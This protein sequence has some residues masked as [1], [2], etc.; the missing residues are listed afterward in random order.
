MRPAGFTP[1]TTPP[2]APLTAAA[3]QP[4][5]P[6]TAPAVDNV[7]LEPRPL[8]TASTATPVFGAGFLSFVASLAVLFNAIVLL[9]GD[10][11]SLP[12]PLPP[13]WLPF[14]MSLVVGG[15]DDDDDVVTG[16]IVVGDVVAL[17]AARADGAV[18]QAASIDMFVFSAAFV[19]VPMLLL[20]SGVVTGESKDFV[21][22]W[23]GSG[24]IDAFVQF[25]Y[26]INQL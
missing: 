22:F 2:A 17:L 23:M 25:W 10:V 11:E 9:V 7:L 4:T 12:P 15:G 24:K 20:F 16:V 6:T 26:G 21:D 14:P 3:A 8:A 1:L 13:L 18:M 19:V 5:S